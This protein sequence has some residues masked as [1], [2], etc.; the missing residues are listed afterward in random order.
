MAKELRSYRL[1]A[2]LTR[3]FERFDFKSKTEMI[4][5]ALDE[6]RARH[7]ADFVPKKMAEILELMQELTAS[8]Q[9]SDRGAD[10]EAVWALEHASYLLEKV[11][12]IR[13]VQI[14]F[15]SENPKPEKK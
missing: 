4:E 14:E 1:E 12:E 15:E 10:R 2:D 8:M 9:A 11:K 13:A 3:D 6:Y 7:D 5:R